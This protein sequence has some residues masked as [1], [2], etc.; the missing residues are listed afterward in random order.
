MF[1]Y[2]KYTKF[3]KKVGINILP[4][5]AVPHIRTV[6]H[7][8]IF[9]RFF[10]ELGNYKHFETYFFWRFLDQKIANL[11]IWRVLNFCHYFCFYGFASEF[12]QKFLKNVYIGIHYSS[13]KWIDQCNGRNARAQ[14]FYRIG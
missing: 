10:D 3:T 1:S 2:L 5:C 11:A 6:P 12:K 8:K 7:S 4:H 13:S 9:I 14:I